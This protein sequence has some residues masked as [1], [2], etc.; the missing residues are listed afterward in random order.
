ML[1]KAWRKMRQ[2]E[3]RLIQDISRLIIPSAENAIPFL[4]SSLTACVAF[5]QSA[6]THDQLEKLQTCVSEV[7]DT[8]TSHQIG[9]ADFYSLRYR[10][11]IEVAN[12]RG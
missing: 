9:S 6:F 4:P 1:D 8:F 7:T 2:N 5:G 10:L 11:K 3:A 12:Q